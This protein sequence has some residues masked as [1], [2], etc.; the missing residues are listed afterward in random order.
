[1]AERHRNRIPIPKNVYPISTVLTQQN[2]RLMHEI[3]AF[4]IT[5]YQNENEINLLLNTAK[6]RNCQ[7]FAVE[8]Q[9]LLSLRTAFLL[10]LIEI[11]GTQITKGTTL[12]T[13][14]HLTDTYP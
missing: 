1:M 14:D 9:T 12:F 10:Y 6:Q 4:K 11:Y 3:L 13:C 2:N 5:H 7:Y 8:Q